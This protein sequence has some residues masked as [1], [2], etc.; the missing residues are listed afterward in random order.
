MYIGL[1]TLYA[2][3]LVYSIAKSGYICN[4]FWQLDAQ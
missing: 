4:T 1:Q 3:T 2:Q